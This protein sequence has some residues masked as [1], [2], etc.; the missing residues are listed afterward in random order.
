MVACSTFPKG[1]RS[2]AREQND[3]R[4]VG[5]RRVRGPGHG[6]G[7][8]AS[9][10]AVLGLGRF[11]SSLALELVSQGSEVLGI[12]RD[13]HV[14][15][16]LAGQ[17]TPVVQAETTDEEAMRQL[18]VDDFEH[19]VIGIGS[20]LE[21]SILTASVLLTLGVQN[22]WAKAVTKAH[23]R[24]LQQIGV[25]HI[26]RPEHDMGV[27]VAHLVSGTMLDYLELDDDYAKTS[28]PRCLQGLPLSESQPRDGWGI[29]V[30]GVK[31][32]GEEFTHATS[33]TVIRS[34]DVI[35]VAGPRSEVEKFADQD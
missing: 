24:I 26:V 9:V 32:T 7:H 21:G 34:D 3:Q 14:V 6:P 20:N 30:V 28:P 27:R 4:T 13:E 35:V 18:S 25:G 23:A 33:D 10:V 8:Q 15:Q 2:L 1:G 11:G 12:D 19:A 22:V 5:R 31:R 29:T 17:L 16:S